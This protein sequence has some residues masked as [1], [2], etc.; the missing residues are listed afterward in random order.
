VNVIW[1]KDSY[2]KKIVEGKILEK[3]EKVMKSFMNDLE[4]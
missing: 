4:N 2:L 3:S 1:L